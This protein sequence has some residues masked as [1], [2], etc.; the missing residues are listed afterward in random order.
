[1]RYKAGDTIRSGPYKG[2]IVRTV[3]KGWYRAYHPSNVRPFCNIEEAT[4][5]IRWCW[6]E[7]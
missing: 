5:S 6:A 7:E 4:T 1:M 3:S 2:F